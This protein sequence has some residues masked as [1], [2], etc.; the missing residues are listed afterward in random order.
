MPEMPNVVLGE[1]IE[2]EWGNAIRDRTLQHYLDN[3]DRA[4][5]NPSPADGDLAYMENTGD[6]DIYHAGAWRHLG[7]PV[8]SLQMHAGGTVPVG[9]LICNGALVSRTTYAQLFAQIGTA[10]GAGDGTTTFALPDLRGR[11][12]RGVA[13]SGEG[14]AIGEVFGADTHLHTTV[15]THPI[16]PG[17]TKSG[18][19]NQGTVS[20]PIMLPTDAPIN[21][22]GGGGSHDHNVDI[23][24]FTSGASSAANSGSA[25]TVQAG[26]AVVFIIK[27]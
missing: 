17:S 27:T 25:S 14:D 3:T 20:A 19:S 26:A 23:A 16:N 15:H 1:T 2:S 18:F 8:G 7:D 21:L 12:P 13:A 4:A 24:S 9:W 5:L 10:W 6:V 22:P 11:V